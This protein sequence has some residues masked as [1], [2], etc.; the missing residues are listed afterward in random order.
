MERMGIKEAAP[1]LGASPFKLGEMCRQKK[2]PHY[3][4]GNRIYFRKV[5]LDQWIEEQE[6]EN[7][8]GRLVR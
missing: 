1:Y 3:R 8:S 6:R 4:I 2:I 7:G 5:V